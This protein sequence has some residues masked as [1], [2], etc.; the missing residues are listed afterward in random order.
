MIEKRPFGRTGHMSSATIFGGAALGRV[1]QDEADRTLEVLLEY[2]V[3]HI[4]TANSYG[5]AEK[6][7]GPWMD[8]HRNDFFL[9]TKTEHRT[10]KDAMEHLHRSLDLLRTDH[11]DLWQM[12]VLVKPDE[13]EVAFGPSGVLEAFV[14]A[15]EQGLVRFLGVTG[16]DTA[17]P[18][19]HKRSLQ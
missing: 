10:Y 14:E 8:R 6:R 1:T 12:H 7:I 3:N 9:A 19:M 15:K 18:V 13:W 2:G 17:I 16:H 5:E 11:I 4:D